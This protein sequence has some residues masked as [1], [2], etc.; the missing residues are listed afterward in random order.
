[1]GVIADYQVQGRI[2]PTPED[3]AIRNMVLD[4]AADIHAGRDALMIAQTEADV[5]ELNRQAAEHLARIREADGWRP[6][7]QRIGLADGNHAQTGD[8]IQAR[9]NDHLITTDGQWLANRDILQVGRIYGFGDD[10]QVEVRRRQAD[11]TWS[12]PFIVPAAYAQQHATLG[13]ASTVYAAQG[14]TADTAHALITA[15][16][17]RETLYVAATRGRHENRL[18]VVTGQPG[19]DHQATPE[20]VLGPALARPASESAATTEMDAALD[21]ADHPARL[22]YLYQQIT[23]AQRAAELDTAI[24]ARLSPGDYARYRADPARPALHHAIREAQLAGHDTAAIVTAITEGAMTGARS[25]AAVLHGR[26][27]HLNL[28]ERPPPPG[29]AAQLPEA[30]AD[31]PARQA[32]EAMDERTRSIGEQ[33]AARPEPWVVDRLGMPPSQPGAL[34]EDWV[35][36]AGRAGFCRQAERITDPHVAIGARPESDPEKAAAWD[37]AARAL[38]LDTAEHDLRAASRAQLERDVHAYAQAAEA[39]PPDMGRQIDQ[40]RQAAAELA[41]QAELD[42]AAGNHQDAAFSRAAATGETRLAD[43]LQPAHETRTRW[44]RD[45]E[46]Q[47]LGARAARQELNSRGIQPAPEPRQP[48]A[49]A[50]DNWQQLARLQEIAAQSEPGS[51]TAWWQQFTAQADKTE[52]AIAAERQAAAETGQPWPP[53]P[54]HVGPAPETAASRRTTLQWQPEA[55]PDTAHV[56]PAWWAQIKTEQTARVQIAKAARRETAARA[57]PVTDAEIA[58]YGTRRQDAGPVADTEPEPLLAAPTVEDGEPVT[59]ETRSQYHARRQSY[60]RWQPETH[61]EATAGPAAAPE[62]HDTEPDLEP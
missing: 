12:K 11:G 21:A 43:N 60:A 27:Q 7:P 46:P 24:G 22:I 42:R 45:H 34:R 55:G 8:W 13:Y 38:N 30:R 10:R 40:H 4:W 28:P 6:G 54:A 23:A 29:W 36:R 9:L 25:V 5:T 53:R 41:R 44:E 48:D 18:H 62:A 2:F 57:V 59:H 14:R 3:Q 61:P 37:H 56:D 31:G 51:G 15:G 35:T 20:A 50:A 58:L 32:A 26:L 17:N 19:S 49:E 47:R 52:A 33:H 1:V 16:M 39:A